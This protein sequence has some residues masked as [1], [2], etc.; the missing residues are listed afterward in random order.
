MPIKNMFRSFRA[1]EA[2]IKATQEAQNIH[3]D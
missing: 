2:K 1:L 3:P